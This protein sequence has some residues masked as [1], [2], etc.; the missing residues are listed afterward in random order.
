M[1]QFEKASFTSNGG[2]RIRLLNQRLIQS[3]TIHAG[4]RCLSSDEPTRTF[5]ISSKESEPVTLEIIWPDNRKT[6]IAN[7]DFNQHY[8]VRYSEEH[9]RQEQRGT[10]D[11]KPLFTD[12][13]HLLNYKHQASPNVASS[14]DASK[15][16]VEPNA[17]GVSWF[18]VNQDGWEELWISSGLNQAPGIFI[19]RKGK[20]FEALPSQAEQ[21]APLGASVP[22][23]NGGGK[24][25]WLVAASHRV[26]R[27]NRSSAVFF[28]NGTSTQPELQIEIG[29]EGIGTLC[30]ADVDMDGDQDLFI[31]STS[32][33]KRYPEP[34]NSQIWLNQ[35]GTLTKS[36]EWSQPFVKAGYINAAVFLDL[37][38]DGRPDLAL[39][40]EWGPVKVFHNSSIG[41]INQTSSLGL[42][43][44][45]GR[46]RSVATGDFDND[47]KM[48]LVAGNKGLNTSST[49]HHHSKEKI[50]FGSK[51]ENNQ[52]ES[53]ESF[54]SGEDWLPNRD[55][56]I[57]SMI[58]PRAD[59]YHQQSPPVQQKQ[60]KLCS[61]RQV[62]KL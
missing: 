49:L 6:R 41:F 43:T 38:G 16:L 20:S 39:A 34:V 9:S 51:R 29:S 12:I 1:K 26:T 32:P 59:S 7:V 52:V 28:F 57:L 58:F 37:E 2:A 5:A 53:I 21:R 48:D 10:T 3:Q 24:R 23:D 35:D 17:P 27:P 31:G 42:N 60:D 13:S 14:A 18:G 47:G 4:G 25:Y 8:V 33:Y 55:R 19:N 15:P 30:V 61:G 40:T 50:W 45:T 44:Q 46:S 62:Q 11:N 36:R 22:W 56:T 54:L